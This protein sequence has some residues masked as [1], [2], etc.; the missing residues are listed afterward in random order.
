MRVLIDSLSSST[1]DSSPKT[2]FLT[3]SVQT[4][5]LDNFGEVRSRTILVDL[6]FSHLPVSGKGSKLSMV[7]KGTSA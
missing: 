2:T 6:L 4:D 1:S 7:M 5:I 3:Y